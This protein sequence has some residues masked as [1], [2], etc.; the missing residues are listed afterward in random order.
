MPIDYVYGTDG[1]SVVVSDLALGVNLVTNGDRV[2][3]VIGL[4]MNSHTREAYFEEPFVYIP[5]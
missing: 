3:C 4:E 2:N 1:H 5:D